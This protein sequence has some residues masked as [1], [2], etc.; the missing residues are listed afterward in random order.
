S[1][2]CCQDDSLDRRIVEGIGVVGGQR[3]MLFCTELP[4]HIEIG[5]DG[6]QDL[7]LPRHRFENAQHLLAPPAHA[8]E[9]NTDRP[10]GV[11]RIA[12]PIWRW[13]KIVGQDF[14]SGSWL[15]GAGATTA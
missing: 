9:C 5:L 6:A 12:R 10:G 11:A 8:D 1:M 15:P 14:T 2:R 4:N 7:N 13:V 3:D